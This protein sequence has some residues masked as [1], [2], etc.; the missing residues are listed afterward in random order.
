MTKWFITGI[1]RGLGEALAEAALARGD[2]VVGTTRDGNSGIAASRGTLHVLPLEVGDAAAIE[3]TVAKAFEL[4]GGLDVIVN[5]AAYGLLGAIENASDAEMARLFDVNV[6]GTFRVIRAAL[7]KLRA[8]GR[9]HIINI[10]SIAGRAPMAGSGLY[11]AT[12]S[13]VEGL[14]QSLAQEVGP[15]GIKVTVVAPGAFRTDFL[16]PHSICKSAPASDGYT[17]SVGRTLCRLDEMA[18][19]QPGDPT[20]AAQALLAVVDAEQPPLHLLLGSDALRR[21]REKLDVLIEE[22]DRWEEVTRGTDFPQEK[23]RAIAS[24][25]T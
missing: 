24:A 11:A 21:A 7:P 1:S 25:A 8:K 6:F 22:M 4:T 18:G 3:S 19:K 10:T 15:L 9:G 2:L 13:A 23:V 17:N 14:S 16:S 20:R 5:N 12:K